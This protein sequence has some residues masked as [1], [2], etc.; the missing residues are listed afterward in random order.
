MCQGRKVS[1][2]FGLEF[3]PRIKDYP[4]LCKLLLVLASPL[5]LLYMM[6]V[7]PVLPMY[8]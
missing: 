4:K 8:R 2:G 1:L 6:V 7:G 3:W 5:Y